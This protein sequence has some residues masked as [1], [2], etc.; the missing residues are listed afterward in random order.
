MPEPNI[1]AWSLIMHTRTSESPGRQDQEQEQGQ[2]TS[3]VQTQK[4]QYKNQQAT[5][6]HNIIQQQCW[7]SKYGKGIKMGAGQGLRATKPPSR[8]GVQCQCQCQAHKGT[9]Y[10]HLTARYAA[11]RQKD[12]AER[13][14]RLGT[15]GVCAIFCA[16]MLDRGSRGGCKHGGDGCQWE[17]KYAMSVTAAPFGC[18]YAALHINQ[19][20][21]KPFVHSPHCKKTDIFF[22]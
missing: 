2:E 10:G 20:G 3:P 9:H 17:D 22:N 12:K 6:W 7:L 16:N 19:L 18:S 15:G 4:K 13:Q 8:K 14:R 5:D 21:G 1:L 11:K